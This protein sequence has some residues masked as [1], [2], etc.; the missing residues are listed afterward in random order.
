MYA[1]L[2]VIVVLATLCVGAQSRTD[3]RAISIN[4]F[5][6]QH[7][8]TFIATVRGSGL[9]GATAVSIG[10]APFTVAVE[11]IEVEAPAEASGR[12]KSQIELVK[13]R[14]HIP[15]EA[16][17][18]RYPIRLIT[19]NGVSNAL[20]LHI[21]DVPV[22]SEPP[23]A[24]ET[25]ETAVVISKLPAVYAG[26]LAGRGEADYYSF[27]VDSGQTFTFEA[28][29]GFPQ[30]AAAG[31][32]ATVPNFDPALTIY[33]PSGSWFDPGRVNRIAYNDE[34]AWVFGKSTDAYL[35]HR[36]TKAGDY[37][38][39][40]EAFAGQG[41]P[42]YSYE[43]KIAPGSLPR[44]LPA[45]DGRGW[46]D[47]NWTRRL[48]AARLSQLD[49][50]GGKDDKQPI[51][52]TYHAG[53]EPG[54]FK[55]PGTLEGALARPGETHRARFHLDKPADI[56]IEIETPAAAPPYF[57]PIFRLLNPL[58]E[59]VASNIFAGKGACTGAMTKSMQAKTILPLRDTGDYTL[60]I[61]DAT[62]DLAGAD[63]QYRV[64]VRPQVAHVGQ[65]KIEADSVNLTQG[66]AKIIR[67]AFDREEDYQGAVTVSAESLPPGVS[68]VAAA[69]FE[70]EKDP[71]PAVGKRERYTPR[72]ERIVVVLTASAEAPVSAEP[73][74]IRLLVRPLVGGKQGDVLSSKTIPMMVLPKL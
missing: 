2:T 63:F 34:P 72:T 4:P 67:V 44:D 1:R 64:Q 13:L 28:I 12:N 14:V 48:D 60:E 30:V 45:G 51:I 7:G 23:G 10:K 74:E 29:S 5:I 9:A 15:P 24:H 21:V 33:E 58:G 42:D 61:R 26:Q 59:E 65:V 16:K 32:A 47:R 22:L 50:R 40:V 19:R 43:L 69:D 25:R 52:E 20:P 18:G 55:I 46:D 31:S 73:Q 53:R 35:V 8:A 37:L 38:L 39:R 36:F 41:G 49:K 68:A 57:N 66:Q 11:G 70:P 62:A 27:H 56:A 6:G 71:P 17:P 54:L 3:P